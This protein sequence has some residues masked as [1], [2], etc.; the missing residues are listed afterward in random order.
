M[1]SQRGMKLSGRALNTPE[2]FHE[3]G[4]DPRQDIQGE[5]G[6]LN[7]GSLRQGNAYTPAGW[8]GHV[9]GADTSP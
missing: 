5:D 4:A 8:M 1:Q 2:K 6:D 7:L 9:Q 3:L